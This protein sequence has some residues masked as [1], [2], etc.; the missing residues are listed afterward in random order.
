MTEWGKCV[1]LNF[2][3]TRV[4]HQH[5]ISVTN[6]TFWRIMM[7]VTDILSWRYAIQPGAKFNKI[8]SIFKQ[9]LRDLHRLPTSYYTRIHLTCHQHLNPVTNAF[10]LQHPLPTSIRLLHCISPINKSFTWS[11]L[12][13]SEFESDMIAL[14][15]SVPRI[16]QL[17]S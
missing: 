14:V 3:H 11:A 16:Y 5:Q 15:S 9:I 12:P 4:R 7:L 13:F 1:I 6:I 8:V 10:G 2:D 17:P